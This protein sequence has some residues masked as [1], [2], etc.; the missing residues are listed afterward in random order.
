MPRREKSGPSAGLTAGQRIF[1]RL[2]VRF[3]E[4]V[5]DRPAEARVEWQLAQTVSTSVRGRALHAGTVKLI[6]LTEICRCGLRI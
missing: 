5:L 3:G 4:C 2:V 6:V 1:V